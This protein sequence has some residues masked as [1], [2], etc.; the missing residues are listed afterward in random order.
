MSGS[1]KER[2]VLTA[3]HLQQNDIK[4]LRDH[5]THDG[6][7][8]EIENVSDVSDFS[9]KELAPE[10]FT[11]FSYG[12]LLPGPV[13][14]NKGILT[15]EE[16][17]L[18]T[19]LQEAGQ[20][21]LMNNWDMPGINDELKREFLKQV[22]HLNDN[23]T[24]EGGLTGYA[25]RARELLLQSS[26]GKNPME[27]WVP[28]VPQGLTLH[29]GSI[30]YKELEN[31]GLNQISK[32]GFVLV[33]GGLGE[34]LGYSDIKL[35]LPTEMCT[36][37]SYLSLYCKQ[38]TSFQNKYCENKPLPLAIMVSDDTH[39]KTIDELRANNYFGLRDDQVTILK[40]EKVPALRDNDGH[41]LLEEG[42]KYKIMTKPHGHGDV[43]YL[44]ARSGTAK[45][46]LENGIEWCIFM[47][48]T[49]GLALHSLA[50]S[51][52][53]SVELGLQVNSIA[54]PR[55]AKQAIGAIAKLR[56]S[57]G[58]EMTVNVEYNQ[59]DPLLRSLG[60][61]GDSND[62]STGYSPF[63]GN[64]NQ[65]ILA[66]E[67]YCK[68]LEQSGGFL[69]EF[70]NPKY[71]DDSRNA[72]KKPTRLEC[73]MQDYPRLLSAE[74]KVGFTSM[75]PWLCFSPVKNSLEDALAAQSKGTPP[76]CAA[77]GEADQY[78]LWCQFMKLL[79]CKIESAPMSDFEGVFVSIGPCVVVEPSIAMMFE[80]A[81]AIFRNPSHVKVS[82]KST[83]LL[84]GGGKVVID[85]LNL[86][87]ALVLRVEQGATL[88]VKS[89]TVENDGWGIVPT[90]R[91][92]DV[93]EV[94]A[95]RGYTIEKK[96]QAEVN[97]AS[98]EGTRVI[99]RNGKA[100]VGTI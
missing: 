98:A 56:S 33:A 39:D 69:C 30:K 77:S 6:G 14:D 68:V 48:D 13:M 83:L 76:A 64:I 59:L 23:C 15:D 78:N 53:V 17:G 52:G 36:E 63:P 46:W 16:F 43:H 26:E 96:C 9:P 8:V 49:N 19:L 88:H 57:D 79:G 4:E 18:A 27:G 35:K 90:S 31:L 82:K 50:A 81:K 24:G 45:R 85:E 21:H 92:C 55:K 74:D 61:D 44:M 91:C 87:G 93:P 71:T 54:I 100:G 22:Q 60:Q 42:D 3:E 58:K 5:V 29:P 66:L 7:R 80:E 51:I 86:D 94:T 70:V 47:Q 11:N 34:R 67:P 73:M 62:P 99:E 41:F 40:Q 2:L 12:V 20:G 37:T 32:C 95:M 10:G 84:L 65:L 28:S 72:F 38:I 89:L 1:A 25:E 97:V 75:D